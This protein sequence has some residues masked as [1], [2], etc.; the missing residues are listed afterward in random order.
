MVYFLLL[1]FVCI[2]LLDVYLCTMY[3]WHIC[4]PWVYSTFSSQKR[5]SDSL[6]LKCTLNSWSH[7]SKLYSSISH[8][9]RNTNPTTHTELKRIWNSQSKLKEKEENQSVTLI[10][11]S[12]QRYHSHITRVRTVNKTHWPRKQNSDSEINS[13]S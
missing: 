3:I 1:V 9:N 11:K 12:T 10:S 2:D 8:R 6:G 4:A 5:L 7:P 13:P